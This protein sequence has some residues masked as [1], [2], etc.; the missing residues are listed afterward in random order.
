[1]E[2]YQRLYNATENKIGTVKMNIRELENKLKN[3]KDDDSLVL[4]N[5]KI[6]EDFLSIKEPTKEMLHKIIDKIYI[7]KDKEVEVHYKVCNN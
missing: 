1:M 5:K 2:T 4:N 7:N 3:I 6:I